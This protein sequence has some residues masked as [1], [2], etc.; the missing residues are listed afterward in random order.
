MELGDGWTP[1]D[2]GVQTPFRKGLA[3]SAPG[4]GKP[5]KCHTL[6]DFEKDFPF[7][8]HIQPTVDF[9]TLI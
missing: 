8:S 2:S 3:I 7:T 5:Q 9:A 4:E 6:K 1:E